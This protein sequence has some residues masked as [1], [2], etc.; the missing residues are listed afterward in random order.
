MFQGIRFKLILLTFL[1]VAT[2]TTASSLV[3]MNV[4]DEFILGQL[5]RR[6]LAIGRSVSSAAAFSFVSEDRLALDNLVS[7]VREQQEDIVFVATVDRTGRIRSHS[8]L[9]RTGDAFVEAPGSLLE[10]QPD[11]AKVLRVLQDGEPAFHFRV[12]VSFAGKHV[13]QVHLGIAND[14]LVTAQSR[15]RTKVSLISAVVLALG[16]MGTFFISRLITTPIRALARC[17]SQLSAGRYEDELPVRAR[18]ELGDLSRSFNEMARLIT[19][20]Q[21]SLRQYAQDLEEAYV[22]T[23]KVLAAAIDAR[24]PYT[25]GHS[26][27]VAALSVAIGGVLDLDERKLK[28]L[29][30]AC[31]FHDV[32]KIRTPDQVLQKLERLDQE[33]RL[34]IRRHPED[35]ADILRIVE[36]LHDLI[37][38]VLHHH[39]W[40]DGRGYPAGL[41]GDQIP[42]F[43][44]I[45][46]IADAYDAMTSSRTYRNALP[47][48][49]AVAELLSYRGTQFHPQLTDLALEVLERDGVLMGRQQLACR[50]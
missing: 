12:P 33:E 32:G 43:A 11:G 14:A 30:L 44:A 2:I 47:P 42:L 10:A 16:V 36:S 41:A 48:E 6:G 25:L 9:R 46:A 50:A 38:A 29:E 37:P 8:D 26:E 31:L 13:G 22:G 34:L 5:V 45:I 7:K 17:V 49:L 24:D 39:E 1:L 23:V 35:G 20:Q 18:D 3:V 40:Y 27:R 21:G 4:M 19:E 28:D 15:A